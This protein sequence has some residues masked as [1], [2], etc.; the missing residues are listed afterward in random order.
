MNVRGLGAGMYAGDDY[1]DPNALPTWH[2]VSYVTAMLKGQYCEF[3]LRGGDAT[4]GNL[5]TLYDGVRPQHNDYSPMKLQGNIILGTGGDNSEGA[6]GVCS[7]LSR[8]TRECNVARLTRRI[9]RLYIRHV[10]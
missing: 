3:S 2:N 5:T 9:V 8:N 1:I 10:L 4:R 6:A 7:S